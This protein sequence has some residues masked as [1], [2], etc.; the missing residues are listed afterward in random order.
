L[1]K[2]SYYLW[3]CFCL[4]QILGFS[5]TGGAN[6]CIEAEPICSSA[7][8]SFANTSDGSSA[9]VGPDYGC[10]LTQPNPAWFFLQIGQ[11]GNIDLII[12]Q[13]TT[14]GGSPNIDVDFILYGPFTNTVDACNTSLTAANT[15]DCS[16]SPNGI[17]TANILNAVSGQF[18]LLL[19]TNFSGAAGFISISQLTGDGSTNCAIL[20]N[21]KACE[22]DAFTLDATTPNA[23][24][25]NWYIED[26]ANPGN[27]LIIPGANTAFYDVYNSIKYR[28]EA[29]DSV[30]DLI[31]LYDYT[32]EFLVNPSI[33]TNILPYVICDNLDANDGIGTFDFNTKIPEIL[34]GQDP[35]LFSITFYENETDAINDDNPLPL[36][37]TNTENPEVIFVRIENT[38]SNV[39]DCFETGSFIIEV[40][41]NPEINL[42]DIYYLCVNTNGTEII[43]NPVI[44]TGLSSVLYAFQWFETSNPSNILSIDS[45][46]M[47]TSEG[48]YNVQITELATTCNSIF[49]TQVLV[50][51]PPNM[52]T[53]TTNEAFADNHII[54]V[55]ATGSG[56]ALYEF[57][58]D[59]GPWLSSEPNTNTYTFSHVPFGEHIIQARD[60]HGCGVS[61]N[62]VIIMDYPLFFTPNNDGYNDTWQIFG[63]EYQYDTTIYIFDRYGKL[64]KQLSP[65]GTGWDGTFNGKVL[66]ED[67]YWFVVK[68]RELGDTDGPQKEFKAHFTL[69]R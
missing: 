63:I 61:S 4:I 62:V 45:S 39:V 68:Y 46:Y 67:D 66:P 50:S 28:A 23:V 55:T 25:Y 44:D 16:Y 58:I 49:S 57:S 21:Y 38:T 19:V 6:F 53:T 27:Y 47:P 24:N 17:E 32:V 22:G 56:A 2:K 41:L 14:L 8:F 9:E 7:E 12:E 48:S 42:E 31:Q 64:L 13:S 11:S 36:I 52:I 37:Y 65:K 40:N 1:K 15:I 5:Q 51:S 60:I 26:L 3:F 34:N 35:L 10:L 69:K 20:E 43:G 30:G 29:Y 18:Y 33:P 59:N 54:N